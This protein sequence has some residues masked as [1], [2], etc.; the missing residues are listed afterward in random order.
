MHHE[1]LGQEGL[2]EVALR[3]QG[4]SRPAGGMQEEA[5]EV[6]VGVVMTAA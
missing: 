5:G 3:V 2:E 4:G 1:E 6:G